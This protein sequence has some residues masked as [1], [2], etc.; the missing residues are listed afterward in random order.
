MDPS[1]DS[2]RQIPPEQ[3]PRAEVDDEDL[4]SLID[5]ML[6]LSPTQRLEAAQSFVKAF[7]GPRSADD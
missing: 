4:D 7:R 6:E 1:T 5:W 2:E 3:A